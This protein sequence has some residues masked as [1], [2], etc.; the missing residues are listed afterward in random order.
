MAE[1]TTKRGGE[2]VRKVIEVLKDHPEGLPAKDVLK[3]V[4]ES[5]ELTPFEQSTYPNNPTVR[6]FEKI[7]RFATIGPV[8]AGWILKSQGRW[9]VTEQGLKAYK[10]FKDPE[11]LTSEVR[12]LYRQW[13]A[14]R[15]QPVEDESEDAEAANVVTTYEGS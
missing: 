6:R 11:K 15:P 9:T 14:S 3:Q 8:K 13:A 5:I 7:G 1:I 2:L 12:R 4:E 10:D